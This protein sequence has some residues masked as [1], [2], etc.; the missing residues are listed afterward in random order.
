MPRADIIVG[1]GYGD[2]GKGTITE[3]TAHR[4]RAGTVIRYNGGAQAA[5]NVVM[6]DGRQHTFSQF[7]S[8]TL[9]GVGTHLSRFMVFDIMAMRNEAK[10]LAFNFNI[11]PLEFLTVDKGALLTTPYH[12]AANRLRELDRGDRRHGSC[13]MGVG[14]TRADFLKWGTDVSPVVE[15]LQNPRRLLEKLRHIRDLKVAEFRGM[16]VDRNDDEAVKAYDLLTIL[17]D[18]VVHLWVNAA[19]DLKIVDGEHLAKLAKNSNIVF[20]GAQGVLLDQDYG[21]QPYTT[22]TTTTT[23]NAW[24]LLDEIGYAHDVTTIG[25]T[26]TYTTRHGAGPLPTELK[27][28][29]GKDPRNPENHWQKKMRFGYLDLVTLGYALDVQRFESDPVDVLA[30]T[31]A[32]EAFEKMGVRYRDANL[33]AKL[34]PSVEE[35]AEKAELLNLVEHV[36]YQPYSLKDL[37]KR[38]GIKV[39]IISSGP[40]LVHKR[41]V[42]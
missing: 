9:L 7:G 4:N 29:D 34:N 26:R 32:D 35:Q 14:D 3:F 40:C 13:G 1:L 30:V 31:H 41:A 18:Y 21:F 25:V 37:E 33:R 17:P 39:G 10:S 19:V 20:E 5:H 16:R 42:P 2:E 11:N 8:A 6:S 12:M 38:T 28:V 36:E 23:K 22:W 15:D 27:T 24:T